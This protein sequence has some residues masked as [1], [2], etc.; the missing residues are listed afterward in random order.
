M[1]CNFRSFIGLSILT[2]SL[3]SCQTITGQ[4]S[5][6]DFEKNADQFYK[7]AMESFPSVAG[8][9]IAVV[10]NGEVVY[11]KG[12]G[13]ANIAARQRMTAKTDF[14]IASSTKS[15]TALLASI[16][17]HRGTIKLDVPLANYFPKVKFDPAIPI[18]KI[19]VRDLLTHTSG[20]NNDGIG[21]RSAYS[22]D[23]NHDLLMAL[24]DHCTPNEVG[25]GNYDYTN[26]GYNIYG[27]ILQEHLGKSWQDGLQEEIFKP[28]GMQQTSAY[29]SNAEKK[30]WPLA[31]PYL[32][33]SKE[34]IEPVYLLKKDNTMQSAGGLISTG[35]DLAKWLQ[36][37]LGMGKFNGQQVFPAEVIKQT[38]SLLAK[39]NSRN[40]PFEGDG[41]GMGWQIGK[42]KGEKVVS[43]FGGFPGYATHVSFLPEK[44]HGVVVLVN[45]GFI[46]G[47]LM[48]LF[49]TYAYDNLLGVELLDSLYNEQLNNYLQRF[50]QFSQ[51]IAAG[52]VDR[53]KRTWQLSQPFPFYSGTYTNEIIG[54]IKIE[55]TEEALKVSLGNLHCFATPY[56]R[57]ESIRVE[58][59]PG[60]GEIM[61]FEI[62]DK[63]LKGINFDD[64]FFK[65][66]K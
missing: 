19:K 2:I 33:Y 13:M 50:D 47:P 64:V 51:R 1:T 59:V 9:I 41:Y 38:Q 30:N 58:L 36:V 31:L 15:F 3:L 4:E 37:Q 6:S 44:G 12:F 56:T 18:D 17:D 11:T 29:I 48:N 32:G 62:K 34:R 20:I 39:D 7:K 54:T 66:K 28:L 27:L 22:G 42:Y 43:H 35:E 65:K 49:A 14:Y 63:K 26:V 46:G 60:S 53:A 24:M 16:Y 25:H 8:S 5:N 40:D 45:D 21:F 55:G 10:K 52:E 23:H 57:E 61:V